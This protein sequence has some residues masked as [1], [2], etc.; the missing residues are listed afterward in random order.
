MRNE[1]MHRPVVKPELVEYM[2]TKQKKLPGEL[3]A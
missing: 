2:R 3:G 1:M